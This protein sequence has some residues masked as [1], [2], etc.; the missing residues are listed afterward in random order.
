MHFCGANVSALG[1]LRRMEKLSRKKEAGFMQVSGIDG[2][3]GK[4]G[5]RDEHGREA[6]DRCCGR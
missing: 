1:R 6:R 4:P 5:E 2:V 3:S